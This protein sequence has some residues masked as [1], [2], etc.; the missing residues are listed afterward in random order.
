M[1]QSHQ[2][3]ATNVRFMN[4]RSELDYGIRL[5]RRVLEEDEFVAKLD[6]LGFTK[7]K[8]TIQLMLDDAE[9]KTTHFAISF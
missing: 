9:N 6:W 3:W 4:D 2:I 5:V 1:L 8:A 7:I